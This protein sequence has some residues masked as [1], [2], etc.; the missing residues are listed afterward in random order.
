[1]TDDF[2]GKAYYL[3]K[4]KANHLRLDSIY[5]QCSEGFTNHQYFY[6]KY[7]YGIKNE[8]IPFGLF[9]LMEGK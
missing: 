2:F 5:P 8:V 9:G 7:K 1:M 4:T 6:T 3:D